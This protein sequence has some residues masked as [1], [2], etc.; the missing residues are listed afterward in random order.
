MHR[1]DR[2]YASVAISQV[3]ADGKARIYGY[4]PVVVAKT[5]L[6]LKEN[7]TTTPGIFRVSGSNKRIKELEQIFNTPP[8]YG[9]DMTWQNYSVHDAASAFRR[10]LNQL[11]SPIIPFS[12]YRPFHEA[13]RPSL[14]SLG[15]TQAASA[16]EPSSADVDEAVK[17]YRDLIKELPPSSQHLL[18]YI[19]DLLSIF[20]AKSAENLMPASNLAM[21]FQP[22]LLRAESSALTATVSHTETTGQAPAMP[23]GEGAQALIEADEVERKKSV[24]VLQFLIENAGSL[25]FELPPAKRSKKPSAP[26]RSAGSIRLANLAAAI[27]PSRTHSHPSLSASGSAGRAM[28]EAAQAAPASPSEDVAR[29][30]LRRK[31]AEPAQGLSTP[32]PAGVKRSNTTGSQASRPPRSPRIPDSAVV[33]PAPA[34]TATATEQQR[35][36]GWFGKRRQS[37]ND[38]ALLASSPPHA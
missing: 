38:A 1:L 16:A 6:F 10:Y 30:K 29:R 13:H 31:S 17:R 25:D 14:R 35:K 33:S 19:L 27:T 12:L 8:I 21:I 9:K 34:P 7:G 4:I 28:P 24:R 22:G 37:V 36:R 26:S 11:P 3:D 32:S 2:R 23:K 5:G 20:H 15:L 18:F